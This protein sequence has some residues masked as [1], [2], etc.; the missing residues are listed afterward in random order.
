M[1]D[2]AIAWDNEHPDATDPA[3]K[4]QTQDGMR[5]L[6]TV[7]RERGG[8]IDRAQ[9][10]VPSVDPYVG[11]G[12]AI[13]GRPNEM[14][15]AYDAARFANFRVGVTTGDQIMDALGRPEW[16]ANEDGT[17]SLGYSYLR[18]FLPGVMSQR[19]MVS[20]RLDSS[21]VLREIVL[22]RDD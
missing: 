16:W 3:L 11:S 20:F 4:A 5:E 2:R 6:I 21:H 19:V 10:V 1:I 9:C 15:Q 18:E 14:V 12:G 8:E 22:P 13:M 17:T 7:A